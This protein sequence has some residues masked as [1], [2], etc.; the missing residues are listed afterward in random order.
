MTNQQKI[1][2]ASKAQTILIIA[3]TFHTRHLCC[4]SQLI[5]IGRDRKY[6]C[7]PKRVSAGKAQTLSIMLITWNRTNR[8]ISETALSTIISKFRNHFSIQTTPQTPEK[9]T[10][11]TTFGHSKVVFRPFYA[12][13]KKEFLRK[14]P[15]W[16][17]CAVRNSVYAHTVLINDFNRVGSPFRQTWLCKNL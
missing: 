3:S 16:M 15:Q 13:K 5:I 8:D 2:S 1:A 11:E 4:F 12:T 10:S 14:C 17:I 7:S 9:I 6:D